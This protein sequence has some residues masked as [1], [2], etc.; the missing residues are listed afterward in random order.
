MCVVGRA[1]YE[2][3]MVIG[4]GL[5]Y[6]VDVQSVAGRRMDANQV[7]A[8]NIA[9]FNVMLESSNLQGIP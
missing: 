5:G 6:I 8:V 4:G 2:V 1:S 7:K 9:R 3:G